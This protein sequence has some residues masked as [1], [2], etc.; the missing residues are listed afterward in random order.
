MLNKGDAL[1]FINEAYKHCKAIATSGHGIELLEKA[2]VVGVDFAE[3]DSDKIMSS[4]GVITAGLQ[5]NAAD[6]FDQFI[7]AIKK[8]RHWDRQEKVMVPA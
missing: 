5:A 7:T 6:F 8:H 2:F 3:K 4:K 1:H